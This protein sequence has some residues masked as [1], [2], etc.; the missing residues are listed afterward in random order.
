MALLADKTA[1]VTGATSGIGRAIALTYADHGADVVI[2]DRRE[3]PRE[4]GSPTQAVIE[5]ETDASAAFVACDVTVVEDLRAAV[6]AADKFGGVDIM[7]NNAG[8][9]V[10]EAFTE[11]DEETFARVVDVN[12]KGVFFGAQAAARRMMETG[13]GTIVNMS[14]VAGIEGGAGY[15][16]YSTTKGAVRLMTYSLAAT[17]G[18]AGIRA[19]A[20]HPGPTE[21]QMTAED[22]P[23]VGTDRAERYL[24]SVPSRRLAQPADV[25]DVA[26]FLASDLADYVNGESILVDGGNV[27]TRGITTE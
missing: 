5:A 20:I 13:G 6:A 19:N 4:G 12:V 15:V 24:Q 21:T 18:P 2:A 10:A 17:L 9:W 14:S 1:V 27:N 7:V 16:I 8:V 11:V 23:F 22:M 3:A 26:T 25:A